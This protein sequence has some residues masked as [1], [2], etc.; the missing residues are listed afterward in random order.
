MAAIGKAL[1]ENKAFY[2]IREIIKS[3]VKNI[4]DDF[5]N[6]HEK[7]NLTHGEKL[8]LEYGFTGIRGQ[9]QDGLSVL[10]DYIIDKYEK[11]NLKEN[12]LYAQILIELMARVEDSTV[13]YRHGI[14]TLKKVQEDA[15]KLL[16]E[17]GMF[18]EIGKQKSY[19]LEQLYIEENI[20]PGGCADLLAISILLMDVKKRLF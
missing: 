20:S 11:S 14:N 13:V 15:K 10:F 4:L 12:D 16:N 1:Y 6:L 17:G 9:V 19:Q 2:E 18:T 8:Y 7:A 5:K 3:M